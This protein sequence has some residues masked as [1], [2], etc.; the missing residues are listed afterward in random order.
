[1]RAALR[2]SLPDYRAAVPHIIGAH[3]NYRRDDFIFP[4]MQSRNMREARWGRRVRP[5]W[6]WSELIGLGAIAALAGVAFLMSTTLV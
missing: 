2:R 5:M 3:A 1:M 6:S 4:R